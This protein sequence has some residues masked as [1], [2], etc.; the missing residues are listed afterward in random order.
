LVGRRRL[1]LSAALTVVDYKPTIEGMDCSI[2]AWRADKL[3]ARL[4]GGDGDCG[5]DGISFG[6]W[7]IGFLGGD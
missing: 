5:G 3:A 6:Q 2:V 7:R 1:G 4:N